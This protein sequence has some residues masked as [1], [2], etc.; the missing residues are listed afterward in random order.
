MLNKTVFHSL[1]VGV[2]GE[3][4]EID[5]VTSKG[6]GRIFRQKAVTYD[7]DSIASCDMIE[8]KPTGKKACNVGVI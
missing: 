4:V 2:S 8:E 6:T 1:S 7:A 5:P 3:K